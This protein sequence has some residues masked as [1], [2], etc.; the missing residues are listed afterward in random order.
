M[1]NLQET[2]VWVNGIYQLTEET[3]VLGKQDD[4]PGDGPA[5]LQAQQLANRTQYLK[6]MMESIADGK[7]HTF[8]K[9]ESDPDGTI[10][11]IHGTDSG[12]VFRVAEGPIDVHAFKYYLNDS[13]I[14][15]II[16]V[17]IGQGSIVNT[18]RIFESVFLA[19]KDVS[20]GNILNNS[21]CWIVSSNDKTLADEYINNAGTLVATGEKIPLQKS[22]DALNQLITDSYLPQ[23]YSAAITDHEGNAAALINDG[24]GFEIPELIV[25]D[26]SSAGEDMPVYVEAHTDEDGNLAL[27]I[28]DDGVV[29]TPDLLAGS[30]NISKDDLPDWSMAFTDEKN[31]VA[32]GIRTGGEVE[33]PEL[34]TAEVNLKKTET[35]GWAVAWTDKN[36][37][38]ALG[39]RDDGSVYPEP[40]S[41][42]IIEF[43]AADTDVIAIL[44]DSY[45]DS[46]FTLKDK[47]YISKLSSLLDYRFKNF[48]VSGNTAP[49][50]NQRLV[51]HSVYFDG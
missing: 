35:P 37:N 48:G 33:V 44:G 31:N 21:K 22:V 41:N 47:S 16:A 39:I 45:T 36:G 11:G 15:K 14:A 49:A 34:L 1:S 10:A 8:Y 3:P 29:E 23:G 13:G 4:V 6:A 51:N 46:L 5:N 38:I 50:I 20:A 25:G 40:E 24:G 2:P 30:I 42:G 19:E 9:T 18:I 27:G 32:L 7:E 28:R 17:V 43:S 26:S 12:K